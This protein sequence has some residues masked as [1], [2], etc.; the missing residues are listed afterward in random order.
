MLEFKNSIKC[1]PKN[2][3]NT[4][5][6][7]IQLLWLFFSTQINKNYYDAVLFLIKQLKII[8]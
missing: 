3:E 7:Q 5:I 4:Y 8:K 6:R 1:L 2:N